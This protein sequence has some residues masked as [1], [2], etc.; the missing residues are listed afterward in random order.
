MLIWHESMVGNCRIW[1]LMS[2]LNESWESCCWDV[3]SSP[4]SLQHHKNYIIM[5]LHPFSWPQVRDTS[6][7]FV[8]RQRRGEVMW[9]EKSK[10]SGESRGES[11]G[12]MERAEQ[13]SNWFL[14]LN[15]PKILQ[16]LWCFFPKPS[17]PAK[18]GFHRKDL[19]S[20]IPFCLKKLN[21]QGKHS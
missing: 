15:A 6:N 14:T 5:W 1:F 8:E 18:E 17:S 12:G 9:R 19:G 3:K 4:Q 16:E 21:E 20:V 13:R 2:H 11:G 10:G 7:L